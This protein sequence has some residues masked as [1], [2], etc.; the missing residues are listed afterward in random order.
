MKKLLRNT[1]AVSAL[2]CVMAT[3]VAP[4]AFAGKK[5]DRDSRNAEIL[6]SYRGDI[7]PFRGD[8][9]PFRGDIN[10][11]RGDIDPFYGDISPFWGDIEPFWGDIDPFRGDIDPFRGDI[12]P[13]WGDIDPFRGD[14]DPFYGDIDPFWGDIAPFWGDIGP[15]WGDINAFWGDIDPFGGTAQSDYAQVMQ[16]LRQ[17]FERA[18]SVF[19][20]AVRH[21]TGQS[22]DDAVLAGL[23]A[24][25]GIDLDDPNSLSNL[26]AA[27]RSRFF[28]DF[29]DGLMGFTGLDRVDHWMPA[30]GWSPALS[31]SVGGGENVVI[32]LLDFSF[33]ASEGLNVRQ[34]GGNT[35]YLGFNHGAAVAGLL[36]APFDGRGLMGMAPNADLLN[37]NPFDETLSTNWTDLTT[38]IEW[39][40]DR[41]ARVLNMSLG[42]PGTTFASG[43]ADVFARRKVRENTEDAVFVFAAGNDGYTQTFDIDWTNSRGVGSLLIVGSVDPAGHISFFSNRPGNAC[44]TV[45]GQ[46]QTGFRLMDRFLV[47]PGELILV[48]DGAGGVVRMSGT[49]F[50][51]PLVAGAAAMVQG[52]W[53]WMGVDNVAD[54]LLRS[55]RDL[56]AP[57]TDAVY[58]RGMLD[59]NAAMSPL[60]SDNLYI[61]TRDTQRRDAGTS[62]I[63]R[64]QVTFHSSDANS[65]VM[66]EDINDSFRDFVVSLDDVTLD[67]TE[68]QIRDA[69]NAEEYLAERNGTSRDDDDDGDRDDDDDDDR[70]FRDTVEYD[71]PFAGRGNFIVSAV[72]SRHDPRE[73]TTSRELPFQMGVQMADP[74]TGRE[75]RFGIGEGAI[76]LSSQ[77]GFGLFSDHRPETGGVNPV[78]G[79]ASGGVYGMA[80]YRI[81]NDTRI[82]F[83][84]TTQHQEEVYTNPWSGEERPIM[85][86]LEPYQATALHGEISHDLRS[87]PQLTL[88][89]T[90]LLENAAMLGAHG[91]GALDFDGGTQTSA[92]TFG[93]SGDMPFGLSYDVS[94]TL[95]ATATNGFSTG[96]L[97]MG[98]TPISTA[99]QATVTRYGLLADGDTMRASLIQ[100]LHIETG[101][102]LYTSARVIDRE[103]GELGVRTDEWRLGGERPL[104]AEILYGVDT[105]EMSELTLY[106]RYAISGDDENEVF[107]GLTLGGQFRLEF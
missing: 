29:Y 39:L 77:S 66:F 82:N 23:L 8:I 96:A 18:D 24:R 43:W 63:V 72:V 31:Q 58:G 93:A 42:L 4:A 64:G 20:A 36:N 52:R 55:A 105:S 88:G 5:R 81:D 56:G 12:N 25:Y 47:A 48:S 14:I 107:S 79:F 51:A 41:D 13:F 91:T 40:I 50:A 76:S 65:I 32:G 83:G 86:G 87:G 19:G 9:D 70:D 28:L 22:L 57:G 6:L 74:V 69:M 68:E 26:D 99:F 78:L 106:T 103:T 16:Q 37:Y 95:A 59:V 102:L 61:M 73:N 98:D 46:C 60:N 10:P 104:Q 17:I 27:D 35:Q 21:E 1:V 75:F 67:L 92:V 101:S 89:Y 2:A 34:A 85:E 54:V 30:I 90:L 100:P 94:A 71:A 38:G 45:N 44:F 7:D 49:S 84:I 3:T 80:G 33:T 11:F 53:G 15:F 97:A 62:G